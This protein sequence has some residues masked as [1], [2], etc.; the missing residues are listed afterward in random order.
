MMQKGFSLFL[1]SIS[2]LIADPTFLAPDH[3]LEIPK[4]ELRASVKMGCVAPTS[5]GFSA[6]LNLAEEEL[7][8]TLEEYLTAVRDIYTQNRRNRWLDL[9]HYPTEVG[10]AVL[11]QIDIEK[12]WGESRML[13][14]IVAHE[15]KVYVFTAAAAK[16]DFPKYCPIF[17]RAFNSFSIP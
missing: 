8:C 17:K 3:W 1:V 10:S 7:D 9:G 5:S 16:S 4:K 2:Y 6:S 12:P 14:L 13:Q 15:R 11:T